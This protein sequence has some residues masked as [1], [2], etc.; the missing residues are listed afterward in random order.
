MVD[1]R[2]VAHT[3]EVRTGGDVASDFIPCSNR[4]VWT[5]VLDEAFTVEDI[6]L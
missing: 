4:P 2:P 6:E 3:R 5:G 1:G